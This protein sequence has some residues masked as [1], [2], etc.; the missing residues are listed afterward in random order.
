[1]RNGGVHHWCGAVRCKPETLIR[2]APPTQ[3]KKNA[4]ARAHALALKVEVLEKQLA[5]GTDAS[6]LSCLPLAFPSVWDMQGFLAACVHVP[7]LI[8]AV[9]SSRDPDGAR[10]GARG[11]WRQQGSGRGRQLCCDR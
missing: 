11:G 1:M 7:A 2:P 5:G 3:E 6:G 9:C 4:E 8:Q 10:E